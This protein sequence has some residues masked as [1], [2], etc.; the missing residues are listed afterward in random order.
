MAFETLSTWLETEVRGGSASAAVAFAKD[1]ADA[2]LQWR[3]LAVL[4]PEGRGP[5]SWDQGREWLLSRSE[6]LRLFLS[7]G[8]AEGGRWKEAL[9]LLFTIASQDPQVAAEPSGARRRLAVAVALTFAGPSRAFGVFGRPVPVEALGRYLAYA[10]AFDSGEL[11]PSF[12]DL[13]AWQM[14]Y[15]VNCWAQDDELVWARQNLRDSCPRP[16]IGHVAAGMVA[17]TEH[18]AQGVSIQDEKGYYGDRPITMQM[19]KEMGAVCGGVSKFSSAVCQAFGVPAMPVGQPGHCAFAWQKEPG[20]WELWNSCGDWLE[21]R[22]H[23]GVHITWGPQA[24]LVPLMEAAQ[25]QLGKYTQ[26][27]N[28]RA[29]AGLAQ[30]ADVQAGMLMAAKDICPYNYMV[31]HDLLVALGTHRNQ[32]AWPGLQDLWTG[33]C[34]EAT[35]EPPISFSKPTRVSDCAERAANPV[36][37]TDSEWWTGEST[38]WLEVDLQDACQIHNVRIKWWGVSVASSFTILS[39]EDG[40]N[41]VERRTQANATETPDGYNGWSE[42]PGWDAPT[43]HVRLELRDG[44][45]DPW[46]MNKLFGIRE[47][48]VRGVQNLECTTKAVLK[49]LAARDLSTHKPALH[50]LCRAI[51]EHCG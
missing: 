30:D 43:R 26:S 51:D 7:S 36:D 39:S 15:V 20:C 5:G 48:V 46:G 31:W 23:D 47:F 34:S 10:A 18:N 37:G 33:L 44:Q 38:A 28:V 32:G 45:L 14:R 4:G 1:N 17:Y 42:V 12:A 35:I 25:L 8:D 3:L 2:V 41:F 50:H 27:E 49:A 19:L 6:A 11:F 9:E 16:E 40:A 13:T 24:W 29:L 21:T 22:Y